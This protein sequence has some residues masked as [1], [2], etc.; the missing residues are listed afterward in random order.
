MAKV[1][2]A[3]VSTRDQSLDR[4]VD[5]LKEY[6]C[7]KIF[8]EKMSGR[9]QSRKE[10]D[11]CLD[12]L[13]EGDSLVIYEL[14]RLG[15]TAKQLIELNQE[16][17]ERGIALEIIELGV[18]TGTPMGKMFYTIMG[19]LAELQVDIIREITREGLESARARGRKG[20]RPSIPE[21][22]REHIKYLYNEKRESADKISKKLGV[23]RSTVYR[24]VSKDKSK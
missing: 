24:V 16:L 1:G 5:R 6:G 3:R 8:K 10:L 17:E 13:R 4:Q 15:R 9:K 7:E 18:K 21:D 11:K 2:Y 12:Y 20:G 22:K 14:N 23:G 19:A